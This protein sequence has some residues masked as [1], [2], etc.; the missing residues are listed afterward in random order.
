MDKVLVTGASGQLG[1]AVIQHLLGT[2]N[3]DA[4]RLIVGSRNIGKLGGLADKGIELRTADFDDVSSLE[5]AFSGVDTVLVVS[6]DALAVKGQRL[7]QHKAAVEAAKRACVKRLVYTSMPNPDQSLVSFAPDHLGTENA[8][9]DSGID[10]VILRNAWYLDN[11]LHSLPNDL[12]SGKWFTATKG[13]KVSNISRD[14]LA[15]AA[16]AVL[17]KGIAGNQTYTLTGEKALTIGEIAKIAA[18]VSGKPLE[19][20]EASQE[21]LRQGMSGAGLPDFVVDM[22]LSTEAN[23]AAGNFDI[24]TNDYET[25]T[26]EKPQSAEDFFNAHKSALTA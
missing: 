7:A 18:D 1:G 13:G 11:Y 12:K 20:I 14:N 5:S 24:V 15:K 3:F 9:K 25:L 16:A 23:I 19:V 17:A 4:N 6:T 8:V 2:Y 26:G 22:L 10:Y 21:Q